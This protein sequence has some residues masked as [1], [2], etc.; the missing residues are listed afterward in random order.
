MTTEKFTEATEAF[1]KNV[2]DTM[3]WLQGTTATILETQNKQMKSASDIY[4]KAMNTA[5]AGINKDNFSSSFGVSEKVAELLQK[6]IDTIT[7]MSKATMKTAMDFG[8]QA[9]SDTFSKESTTKIIESYKKQVE[10]IVAFNKKSFETWTKQFDTTKASSAE[11]AEKFKKE[12]ESTAA[13]SKEK[14][15]SI[16][17]SYSKVAK[18]TVETSKEMFDKLN[19][20]MN[21]NFNTNLKFWSELTNAYSTKNFETK[22]VAEFFKNNAFNKSNGTQK[23]HTTAEN[24]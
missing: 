13:S 22:N 24:N 10:E 11:L 2:N 6:N 21:D 16:I 15:Q 4:N 1:K 20:Q 18:P 19:S 23:K 14:I 7:N 9:S 3:K 12:F 8:K 5:F 17:D